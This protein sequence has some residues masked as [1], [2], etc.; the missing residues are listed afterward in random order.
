LLA[1]VQ[2]ECQDYPFRASLDVNCFT[3]LGIL[4]KKSIA[5]VFDVVAVGEPA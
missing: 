4:Q 1:V 2:P 5:G 3:F